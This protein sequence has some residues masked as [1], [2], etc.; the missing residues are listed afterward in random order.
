M[1]E[2]DFEAWADALVLEG[3]R[4]KSLEQKIEWALKQAYE[5]GYHYGLNYGWAIEQD[6]DFE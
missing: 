2:P 3:L 4:T 5:Q 6:K 1:T